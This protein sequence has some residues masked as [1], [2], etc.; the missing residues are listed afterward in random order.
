MRSK[1]AIVTPRFGNLAFGGL[2]VHAQ[3]LS[4]LLEETMDVT[5]FTTTSYDYRTWANDKSLLSNRDTIF[6]NTQILRFPVKKQRSPKKFEILASKIINSQTLD[7]SVLEQKWLE[8]QGPIVPE[9]V[10]AVLERIEEFEYV[11][12]FSYLYWPILKLLHVPTV[13]KKAILIPLL[14]REFP[15]YF[16]IYKN[17]FHDDLH[18]IFN[19]I[20]EKNLFEE[21]FQFAPTKSSTIGV[22]PRL[23]PTK[24]SQLRRP[25]FLCVGRID[26]GKGTDI[27]TS[28]YETWSKFTN[29]PPDLLILGEGPK[30]LE[31]SNIFFLGVVNEEEK[32]SL[33]QNCL[34]L[35]HLSFK[36]SLSLALLEAWSLGKPVL[37]NSKSEVLL[38]HC[39]R[40]GG[41]LWCSDAESFYETL[42]LLFKNPELRKKLGENGKL[43]VEKNFSREVVSKKLGDFFR[44]IPRAGLKF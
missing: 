12:L 25:Y 27:L 29:N 26:P 43:Y 28:W 13:R 40:S 7:N 4:E 37:V 11:I 41:G 35:I 16:S 31:K 1:I 36:E 17:T 10:D 21:V 2:E 24:I 9:L 15:I 8:E 22:F 39:I 18:Y 3:T 5:I 6:N 42:T 34:G 23:V 32:V 19:T 20:E 30:E 33:L 14:H 44:S 38:G